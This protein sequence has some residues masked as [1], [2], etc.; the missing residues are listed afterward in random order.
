MTQLT[1]NGRKKVVKLF[2]VLRGEM[3]KANLT[4]VQLAG[5]IGISEKS[6]RN[7]MNG[8][9]EFTWS[10]ILKIRNIV[11]PNMPLEELFQ[12]LQTQTLVR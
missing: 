10:E 6:L 2:R 7:K 9:T 5:E 3:V 4:I 8:T 1:V 11:A 12:N